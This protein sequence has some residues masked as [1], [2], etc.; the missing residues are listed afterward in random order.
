ME[1][2][3]ILNDEVTVKIDGL[4]LA[5][6][7]KLHEKFKF[8]IP[9][10]RYQPAVR[11]G[12]W[13]GKKSFFSLSGITYQALLPEILT[14]LDNMNFDISLEDNR[15]AKQSFVFPEITEDMFAS[16]VWPPSHPRAGQPVTYRDYQVE[17]LKNYI[18]NLQSIQEV[19]TGA[20]KCLAGD[21]NIAIS[22]NEN[23]AFGKFLLDKL[24][25]D[26]EVTIAK[27][28]K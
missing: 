17:I 28:F 4:D 26:S 7:K 14:E 15:S 8:E 3:I 24:Q 13:D 27:N 2:K 21:T 10:A 1:A 5:T 12:R 19:A 9:G 22:I 20:G 18:E 23:S 6:R 11:L 16:R 25:H